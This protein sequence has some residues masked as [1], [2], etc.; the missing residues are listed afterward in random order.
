MLR[1]VKGKRECQ[2]YVDFY[3]L[4]HGDETGVKDLYQDAACPL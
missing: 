2:S 3:S 4:T 1:N